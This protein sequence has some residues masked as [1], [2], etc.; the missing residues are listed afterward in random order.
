MRIRF[1]LFIFLISVFSIAFAQEKT[2]TLKRFTSQEGLSDNQVTCMLRDKQGFMWIGTKDG[3]N[4]Y[5]GKEFYVFRQLENDSNSL[6]GNNITCLVLDDDSI[7]WIGTASSGLAYYNFR[8]G[9]FTSFNKSNSPLATNNVNKITYDKSRNALWIGVTNGAVQ[10]L[11]VKDKTIDKVISSNTYYDIIVKDTIPYLAGINESL[12]RLGKLGRNRIPLSDT[13]RTIN[14]IYY[15]TDNHLW[16]GAWDNGL[17]EFDTATRRL[18]TYFFDGSGQMNRSGNEIISITEDEDGTLWCGTKSTGIKFFDLKTRTFLQKYKLPGINSMRINCLYADNYK[19]IWIGTESGLFIYDPLSNQFR[20]TN[21]PAPEVDERCKVMDRLILPGGLDLVISEC[22]LFYKTKNEA[23]YHH[24][25]L[26]YRNEKQQL[27]S[28]FKDYKNRVYIG[29]HKTTFFLD[30]INIT[31]SNMMCHDALK[32]YYFHSIVS[33][34]INSIAQMV[35]KTDTVI[36][37]SL[38]GHVLHIV[39]PEKKNI[40]RMLF[41][42]PGK[43]Y[44]DNL[45]RKLFVDSKSNLWACGAS[46]GISQAYIPDTV[47]FSNFPFCDNKITDIIFPYRTWG[48][49]RSGNMIVNDVYDIA[50]NND[51][52][53]WLTT[54]GSGL[55]KFYPNREDSFFVSHSGIFKSAQGLAKADDDNLWMIAS[56]GLLHYNLKSNHYISYTRSDGIPDGVSGYFFQRNSDEL[57]A[58][59]DKGFISFNPNKIIN[60]NEKPK[61]Y[62]TR[63]WIMD[64]PSDSL[65]I[66]DLNLEHD[67]NFIK[68][69]VSANCYSKTDQTTFMYYL[70]GIDN[71]WHNNQNNPLITYTNLPHGNYT[72]KVKAINS[73]GIE[74]EVMLLPVIITPPFYNTIYFY[75][76]IVVLMVSMVYAFYRYRIRQI[77]KLQE[78]RNKIARDLHDDIGSTLGSIHLYSQIANAKLTGDKTGEI[79]SIL[80]KIENSSV[81]IIDKTGDVVWAAKASND[82]LQNLIMRIEGYSASILGAAGIQFNI[83]YDER[84]ADMKLEMT[85]RKN[86]FLIYKEAVHNI[87]KYANCTEVNITIKKSADK[88]HVTISDNGNGFD[89]LSLGEG[90]G[91]V[92]NG[93]GIKNMKSRAAEIKGSFCITSLSGKGTTI[94]LHI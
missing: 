20:V 82:T 33:S 29:S 71:G 76:A 92:Y 11:R 53:Y 17:H 50:E 69:Y 1:L 25:D 5:D 26:I 37:I 83:D 63:L 6:C 85:E 21:L 61:V 39:H 30:T 70:D 43:D 52:S 47:T 36:V 78:V 93:N 44:F 55:I 7:L 89:S 67:K 41:A 27:Y 23:A 15:A 2:I 4:R 91:E 38:Y 34:R 19:R 45:T 88:L 12:K 35:H 22:G 62:I 18:N 46:L 56:S 90:R 75:V 54:Q 13:A 64:V 87:I 32:S 8:T 65:L 16:C 73:S 79:K 80:E 3:L 74:S 81:E 86:I 57:C 9:K 51:G 94:E 28:I 84:I 24:K 66:S 72:L 10:L 68:F 59:F 48:N 42:R 77:M 14:V 49:K 60:N 31:I 58:G 40:F